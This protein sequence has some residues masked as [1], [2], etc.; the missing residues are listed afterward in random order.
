VVASGVSVVAR[1]RGQVYFYGIGEFTDI[2]RNETVYP[3]P[4]PPFFALA[5]FVGFLASLA[6]TITWLR[7]PEGG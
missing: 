2:G 3:A 1:L 7:D 4:G 6:L 5:A